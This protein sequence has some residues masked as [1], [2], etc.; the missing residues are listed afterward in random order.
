[1]ERRLA[2]IDEDSGQIEAVE[3][4]LGNHYFKWVIRMKPGESGG[5]SGGTV[6]SDWI[7][8][9]RS[10]SVWFYFST[11]EKGSESTAASEEELRS[12]WFIRR[13]KVKLLKNLPPEESFSLFFIGL[14]DENTHQLSLTQVHERFD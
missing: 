10:N 7:L 4:G 13:E 12:V 9:S 5:R 2:V 11:T 3:C 6:R 8:L 1:M 14:K